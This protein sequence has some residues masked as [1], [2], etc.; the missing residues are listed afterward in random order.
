MANNSRIQFHRRWLLVSQCMPERQNQDER[1]TVSVISGKIA[2][3]ASKHNLHK[4]RATTVVTEDN[5]NV[6]AK[7]EVWISEHSSERS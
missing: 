5:A 4:P 2:R 1:G 3:F 6:S 7:N